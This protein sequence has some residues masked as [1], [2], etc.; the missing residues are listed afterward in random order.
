[1]ELQVSPTQQLCTEA[2]ANQDG[3]K[4]ALQNRN[5]EVIWKNSK[6]SFLL[7]FGS[8]SPLA[9]PVSLVSVFVFLPFSLSSGL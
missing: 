5:L 7:T 1:M 2:A 6:P 3:R 8:G 9:L 4:S